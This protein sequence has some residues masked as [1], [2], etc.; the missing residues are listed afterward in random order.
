[1]GEI[2]SRWW[3]P[4]SPEENERSLRRLLGRV[5]SAAPRVR[6]KSR[7]VLA[8]LTA[9]FTAKPTFRRGATLAFAIALLGDASGCVW[10]RDRLACRSTECEKL[11]EEAAAAR[12]EGRS[13][14]ANAILNEAVKRRPVDLDT[15][16]QLAE[17]LWE[18]GREG[19]A[20]AA[21]ERLWEQNPHDARLAVLRAKTRFDSGRFDEAYDASLEALELDPYSVAALEIKARVEQRREQYDLAVGTWHRLTQADPSHIDGTLELARLQLQM[22]QPDYAACLLRS[23]LSQPQL[24]V[25]QFAELNW[26]L[27]RAYAQSQRWNDATKALNEAIE[28]RQATSDDWY[29][30]AYVR[31]K[32]GDQTGSLAAT[33]R[34]LKLKPHHPEALALRSKLL[35]ATAQITPPPRAK[36]NW[37]SGADISPA[38]FTTP[39]S[40]Q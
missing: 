30:L 33:E 13:D 36:G 6:P 39:A 8:A 23:T 40:L 17:S 10:V 20:S 7:A 31:Q 12:A 24:T 35:P 21:F 4:P 15:R 26:Q 19:E 37:A 3:L 27:G 28:F 9:R 14:Q 16:L 18:C 34:A 5:R 11:C 22:D 29:L 25:S 1:M 2:V 38:G 32:T